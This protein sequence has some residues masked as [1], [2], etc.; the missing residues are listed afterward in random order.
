LL[1]LAEEQ[2]DLI[3]M[4]KIRLK[5]SPDNCRD[6]FFQTETYY[7]AGTRFTRTTLRVGGRIL[8]ALDRRDPEV[9]TT[10][11]VEHLLKSLDDLKAYLELPDE[12]FGAEP[13]LSNFV[14]ADREVGDRGI[15]MVDS[16]DPICVA[17]MLFNMEDYVLLAYRERVWFHR[18]LE[19]LAPHFH[20]RTEQVAM[21]FPGHL[22]RIYGAEFATEPYLPPR[23]FEEYVVRYTG[24]MVATIQKYGGYARLH[25]HGRIASAL[26]YIR[27]MGPTAIDPIEPPPQGDVQLAEV[28]RE[29]GKDL[30]LFGNIEARDIE[31]LAPP[32]F[33]KVVVQAL[34]DGTSGVGKGFVLMP[35]ASPYGRTITPTTLAN[36][37]TMVRLASAFSG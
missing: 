20:A 32:D 33:E 27:E 31:Y 34:R 26:P 4:R 5:P 12:V 22:W 15:V 35:T 18:L 25:C 19:K 13:D 10:W 3:R 6:G 37:E 1:K 30:V 2:T 9:D 16:D 7:Q 24:P 36:Y 23:L 21:A 14:D 29:Y 8:T 11:H 17:A 28:R